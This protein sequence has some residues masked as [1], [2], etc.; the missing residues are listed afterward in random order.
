MVRGRKGHRICYLNG[1]VQQPKTVSTEV[2]CSAK[3]VKTQLRRSELE[4]HECLAPALL[5]GAYGHS[6]SS[7]PG[8]TAR[9]GLKHQKLADVVHR[10]NTDQFPTFEYGQGATAADLKSS[11]REVEHLRSNSGFESFRHRSGNSG[12]RTF[13]REILEEILLVNTPTS[14]PCS[15]TGKSC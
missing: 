9:R 3:M 4:T 13:L 12:L 1:R 5:R 8:I 11:Q 2:R 10:Q 6:D 15:R 7:H 14:R